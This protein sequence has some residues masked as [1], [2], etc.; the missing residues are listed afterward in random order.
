[1]K[2]KIKYILY[3][4]LLIGLNA[5]AQSTKLV[6]STLIKSMLHQANIMGDSYIRGDYRTFVQ[7]MH[8]NLIKLMG[9]DSLTIQTLILVEKK[10]KDQGFTLEKCILDSATPIISYK[11][12]LQCTLQQHLQ[13]KYSKGIATSTSTLIAISIDGGERWVFAGTTNK[14]FNAMQKIYPN[15]SPEII[16]PK[17]LPPHLEEL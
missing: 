16:I 9:S 8:P 15:L 17:E 12:E 1:M 5:K 10:I 11:N 7:F 4:V 13:L 14:D 6:D 2:G 3:L